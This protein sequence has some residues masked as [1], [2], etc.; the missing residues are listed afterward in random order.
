[1]LEGPAPGG[2]ALPFKRPRPFDGSAPPPGVDPRATASLEEPLRPTLTDG[3]APAAS[4]WTH[5]KPQPTLVDT[6]LPDARPSDE[7]LR[8]EGP[9]SSDSGSSDGNV[10]PQ[11]YPSRH[12]GDPVD[13]TLIDGSHHEGSIDSSYYDESVID[14]ALQARRRRRLLIV[15]AVMLLMTAVAGVGFYVVRTFLRPV[16]RAHLHVP[17]GSNVAI[18]ADGGK[19]LMF[20]PVRQHLWPLLL[21]GPKEPK[22]R[23]ERLEEETGVAIPGDLR[24][25]VLASLDGHHWVAIV[26][27]RIQPERFVDGLERVLTEE[28]ASG[29]RR[30][31]EL[32]V[33]TGGAAIGQA[34]DGSLVL[35]T[36]VDVVRAALPTAEDGELALPSL[37]TSDAVTFVLSE[38]A[39]R[40]ANARLPLNV[41]GLDALGKI[42]DVSGSFAL[43]SKPELRVTMTPRSGVDAGALAQELTQTLAT[44]KLLAQP[45]P[46]ELGGAKQALDGAKVSVAEGHVELVAP[47]SYEALDRAVAALA[48]ALASDASKLRI[49]P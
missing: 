42:G 3:L 46:G 30:D 41:G 8:F 19:I 14:P 35:G 28:G 10:A 9:T 11:D 33:H 47:W 18:R 32:L 25:V 34:D 26:A 13:T 15:V 38:R 20:G 45:L 12:G 36:G 6:S 44:V 7:A 27:G 5:G 21:E 48:A 17:Q 4:P 1:V 22:R 29:W 24:E 23:L 43:S 49:L 40:G 16:P 31:A 37:G 39:V 2:D